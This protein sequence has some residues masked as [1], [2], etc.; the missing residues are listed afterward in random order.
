MFLGG[1]SRHWIFP[2][3]WLTRG[4]GDG[5]ILSLNYRIVPHSARKV[6]TMG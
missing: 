6:A 5:I 4:A 3:E 1:N 2:S